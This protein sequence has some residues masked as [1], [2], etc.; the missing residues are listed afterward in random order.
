[1]GI[2][3]KAHRLRGGFTK[4]AVEMGSDGTIYTPSF[5]KIH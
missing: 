5:R 2:H 3:I 4:Y 1:M